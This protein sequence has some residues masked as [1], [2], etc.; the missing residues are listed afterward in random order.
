MYEEIFMDDEEL[1]NV[2]ERPRMPSLQKSE[3]C[4]L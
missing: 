3:D 2:V 1:P 4:N